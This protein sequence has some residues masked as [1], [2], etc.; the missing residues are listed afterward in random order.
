MR[1]FPHVGGLPQQVGRMNVWTPGVDS[2]VSERAAIGVALGGIYF[3]AA[4]F[5]LDLAA[6]HPGSTAVWLPAGIMLAAFL[7]IGQW[8]WPGFLLGAFLLHASTAADLFTALGLAAAAV[9]EGVVASYLVGRFAGGRS[10]FEQVRS[11]FVFTGAA[12]VLSAA[13]G[14]TLGTTSLAL[15]GFAAW[16]DYD[17]VWLSW[18]L[19]DAAATLVVTP[20]IVLWSESTKVPWTLQQRSEAVTLLLTLIATALVVFAGLV[21]VDNK[22][23]PLAF[24]CVPF[25]LWAA[26][27]FGPRGAATAVLAVSIGALVGTVRGW[28]LLASFEEHESMLMLQAFLAVGGV[29][30]LTVAAAAQ[31]RR[32]AESEFRRLA[33]RDGLTGL[34]NYRGIVD[35]VA[36]EIKRAQRTGRPFALLLVDLDRLKMINDRYGHAVGSA[37]LQ[38]VANALRTSSRA[39]DAAARYGGDEFALVLSDSN[40]IAAL[41]VATR[42][43]ARLAVDRGLPTISVSVG[44]AEYPRDGTTFDELLAAAD[45]RLYREKQSRPKVAPAG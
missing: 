7:V 5:E 8:V 2:E 35:A 44:I 45:R 13:I 30:S 24:L 41:N 33:V 27:R 19:G 12:A 20:A 3:L 28:G 16:A 39:V 29:M 1:Q 36:L 31:E 43:A 22:N 32:R 40:A 37:A 14:A 4:R 25:L 38:R 10:A 42:V 21:P 15:G 23:Y 26:F 18:W 6:L 34:L 11:V 17:D 9:L